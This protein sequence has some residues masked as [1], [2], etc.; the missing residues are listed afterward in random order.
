MITKNDKRLVSRLLCSVFLIVNLAGCA[1]SPQTGGADKLISA[2]L[3]FLVRHTERE[4]E[5]RRSTADSRR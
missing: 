3:V 4:W 5:G 2:R 1:A